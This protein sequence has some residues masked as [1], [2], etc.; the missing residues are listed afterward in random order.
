MTDHGNPKEH[1]IVLHYHNW[2]EIGD[3]TIRDR[4]RDNGLKLAHKI[5]NKGILGKD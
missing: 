1:P 2:Y 3:K 5:A 4:K